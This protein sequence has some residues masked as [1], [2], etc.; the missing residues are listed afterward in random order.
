MTMRRLLIST[1][2]FLTGAVVMLLELTGTRIISP[3]F[4]SGVYSWAALISVTLG[5]LSVGYWLGGMAI[6]RWDH[7]RCLFLTILAAGASMAPIPMLAEPVMEGTFN[8]LGMIGGTLGSATLLFFIP[9]MLLGMVTPMI[10]HLMTR[11]EEHIGKTAGRLFALSTAGSLIGTLTTGF[12]LIPS[13]GNDT[14]LYIGASILGGLAALGLLTGGA[15]ASGTLAAAMVV[16]V[17]AFAVADTRTPEAGVQF[18]A[19]SLY[20]TV[21]VRDTEMEND[22]VFRELLI[23]GNT[24]SH[25]TLGSDTPIDCPYVVSFTLI[26]WFRP[27][28]KSGLCVGLGAGLIPTLLEAEYGMTFESVEIDPLVAHTA[29]EYFRFEGPLAI[30]DGR[31]YLRESDKSW[32]LIVVDPSSVDSVAIHL[33]SQEYFQLASDHLTPGGVVAVNGMG[34]PNGNQLES[35]RATLRSVF[36][37]V[38]EI[39]AHDEGTYRNG[40]FFASHDPLPAFEEMPNPPRDWFL[41][42]EV[43]PRS[44]GIILTDR[45]NPLDVLSA[46][47]G[48]AARTAQAE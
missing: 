33:L 11:G 34:T 40:I 29:R 37:H 23:D 32:D 2:F 46:P 12:V 19:Q 47:L 28:A 15:K 36:P 14:I 3:W 20:G 41:Q 17:I 5:S 6:A 10:I 8:A 25:V 38:R 7:T 24:H 42:H 43:S 22:Q 4:G 39:S 26:H 21:E 45:Y 30:A 18:E 1:S 27:Q 31:N 16:A 48:P 9:L 35:V 44:G 13:V